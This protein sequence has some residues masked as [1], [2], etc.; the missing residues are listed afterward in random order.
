MLTLQQINSNTCFN[1]SQLEK[2]AELHSLLPHVVLVTVESDPISNI[3]K[4]KLV[5]KSRISIT[6][7]LL[8]YEATDNSGKVL[9]HVNIMCYMSNYI[10]FKIS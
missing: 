1:K 9:L 10:Q 3:E 4:W 8:F 5:R 7:V 2:H 6:M